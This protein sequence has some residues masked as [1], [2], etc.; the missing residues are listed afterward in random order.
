MNGE[1]KMLKRFILKKVMK[2]FTGKKKDLEKLVTMTQDNVQMHD[3]LENFISSLDR[4]LQNDTPFAK[5]LL[6][7]GKEL[8][9][10]YKRNILQNL[11]YN[12]FING[13]A[14]REA[15]RADGHTWI[16]NL[17]VISPTMRCN[18]HCTGCYSGLYVK[19]GELSE[20]DMINILDQARDMGLYFIVISG[21]EPYIMKHTLLRLFKRY[22]DMFFLTYT[23]GTFLDRETVKELAALGNVAPAI[24]VEGWKEETDGRRGEGMWEKINNAMDLLRE[25]G[26]LFGIS[27]T[28]T[29]HNI[30]T[31]TDNK[32]IEYFMNKG[33]LFGWY[34]MFMPVGKD[35]ILD[36]VPTPQQRVFCGRSVERLRNIYPMFLADFWNDGPAVGGCLAGG[37]QYL[38]ILNSGFAEP[39]V[40][41]HFHAADHN[42]REKSIIEVVNS[43]F[44]RDIRKH[45]PYNKNANLR[46]PCMIIDNPE[47]LREVVDKHVE[48]ES[49]AHAEDIVADPK[50]RRWIDNY[51][52]ELGEILNP[53]W[54]KEISN[55]NFRWYKETERYRQLFEFQDDE[56]YPP[57]EATVKKKETVGV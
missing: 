14:K 21:G 55:P 35:P 32:F 57:V 45:F 43:P 19:D 3:T 38:H 25:A 41:A 53:V 10:A 46:M 51:S 27:V 36:L 2:G 39:C 37:R 18:L 44:F 9:P 54:E 16:P 23:N 31:I 30:D 15:L 52:R 1:N 5:I 6:R 26:V 8:S 7:V 42:I 13:H 33:A 50:V 28:Y 12:Q 34:F 20:D 11:I 49:H 17:M 22:N 29:R 56:K 48:G 24:S 4:S 40:F 47:I